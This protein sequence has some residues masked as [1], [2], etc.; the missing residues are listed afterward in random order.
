MTREELEIIFP[1]ERENEM[2]EEAV[3]FMEHD[4]EWV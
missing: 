2:E 1:S 3:V 4:E